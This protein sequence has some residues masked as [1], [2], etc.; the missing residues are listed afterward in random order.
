MPESVAPRC[1]V[2]APRYG[3]TLIELLVVLAIISL[4]IGILLPALA[5]ARQQAR[6]TRA[7]AEVKQLV[8]ACTAY[9]NDH[10][11]TRPGSGQ[12]VNEAFA[13]VLRSG[14]YMELPLNNFVDP[15]KKYYKVNFGAAGAGD[16]TRTYQT[17]AFFYN[18][19]RD[20]LGDDR[21]PPP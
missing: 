5:A 19:N 3:F 7:K 8:V 21:A 2:L 12:D 6:K 1:A 18:Y 13:S 16:V 10:E 15:W 4:L 20:N 14:K 9:M 11:G 17:R